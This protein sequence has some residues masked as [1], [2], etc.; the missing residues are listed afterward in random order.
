MRAASTAA[1]AHA[2]ACSRILSA[3][4]SR[5]S[6]RSSFE[7]RSPRTRYA[8]SRMT[9][10]ATTQPNSDPRPTS[11]TP[12]TSRA[13]DAQA[14]FS[15]RNVQRSFLSSRSLAADA[16]SGRAERVFEITDFIAN[17]GG[18]P[19]LHRDAPILQA[20]IHGCPHGRPSLHFT[21]VLG[22]S[23]EAAQE[24]SPA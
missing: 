6:G 16:D 8:G 14:L 5:R 15:Y 21:N 7:S 24:F 11:S 1:T 12:A 18:S 10:A 13:P 19:H 17:Q 9:A 3:N 2:T 22:G 23:R 20:E 4:T